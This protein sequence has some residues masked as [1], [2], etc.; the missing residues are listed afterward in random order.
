[1][2]KRGSIISTSEQDEGPSEKL[3]LFDLS[4]RLPTELQIQTFVHAYSN[5][6]HTVLWPSLHSVTNR[7]CAEL[8]HPNLI[9]YRYHIWTL[10]ER[11]MNLRFQVDG[12]TLAAARI[13]HNMPRF[14]NVNIV[15]EKVVID[16]FRRSKLVL[17]RF[18]AEQTGHDCPAYLFT[19][20]CH[21]GRSKV[22][23]LR[24]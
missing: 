11:R 22:F 8:H 20:L 1:M 6:F 24:V 23:G 21:D 4:P 17:N 9:L 13:G 12:T 16:C 15:A 14:L 10:L 2:A 19:T 18:G 7:T 5:W 3:P